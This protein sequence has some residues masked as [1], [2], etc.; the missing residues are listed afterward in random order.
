M[1]LPPAEH[2]RRCRENFLLGQQM[3]CSPAEA[4]RRVKFDAIDQRLDARDRARSAAP[5]TA[6]KPRF[7]WEDY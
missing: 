4:A 3:G 1:P 2:L 7:W 6:E 5:D